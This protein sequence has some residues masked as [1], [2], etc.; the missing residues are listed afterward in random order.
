M[1]AVTRLGLGGGPRGLYGSFAGKQ[2]GG[3]PD[4]TPV[5]RL[6]LGGSTRGLYGSFAGKVAGGPGPDPGTDQVT[7]L[8]LAGGPR[9]LY[10]SF[11][12]KASATAPP[13][14]TAPPA[15]VVCRPSK[16]QAQL[17]LQER[18][19]EF[20]IQ[21]QITNLYLS[22]MTDEVFTEQD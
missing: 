16:A 7:R 9:G 20:L 17:L 5:T 4:T 21:K 15:E 14:T 22:E 6:G 2:A 3:G 11:A 12:G 10:G 8:G 19:E 18:Y 13:P 1:T